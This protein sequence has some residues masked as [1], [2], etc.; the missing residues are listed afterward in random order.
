MVISTVRDTRILYI[1]PGTDVVEELSKFSALKMEEPTLAIDQADGIII[2]VTP[3]GV[4]LVENE[5][6][7]ALLDEWQAASGQV[8]TVATVDRMQCV[9][10]SGSGVLLYMEVKDNRLVYHE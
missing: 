9:L 8:V 7:G 10:S 2:H 6:N 5:L 4:R 3:S 1:A